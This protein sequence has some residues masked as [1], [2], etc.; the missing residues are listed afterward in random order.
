[1]TTPETVPPVAPRRML[2]N[3]DQ[4]GNPD[5]QLTYMQRM[6]D[7]QEAL[8]N[9]TNWNDGMGNVTPDEVNWAH[10]GDANEVLRLLNAAIA[11]IE[12]YA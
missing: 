5:A 3:L 8:D 9:L 1:M 7:I 11:F 2:C 6:S 10:V 12:G 4:S